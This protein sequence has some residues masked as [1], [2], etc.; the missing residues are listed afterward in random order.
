MI[1]ILWKWEE[2]TYY[3]TE[4]LHPDSLVLT[5][6][7]HCNHIQFYFFV[8]SP[9]FILILLQISVANSRFVDQHTSTEEDFPSADSFLKL[10][11]KVEKQV[12]G[13]PTPLSSLGVSVDVA[14]E[15]EAS[16][17]DLEGNY[18]SSMTVG[19]SINSFSRMLSRRLCFGLVCK[20][21]MSYLAYSK[22]FASSILQ[23]VIT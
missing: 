17:S 13:A 18:S 7:G 15:T 8:F 20:L 22:M 21:V 16:L 11:L 14:D 19:E 12:A 3:N 1:F 6:R 10:V 4:N 23:N 5:H 9:T 2:G